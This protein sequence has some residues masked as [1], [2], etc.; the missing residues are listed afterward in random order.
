MIIEKDIKNS[1]QFSIL[2]YNQKTTKKNFFS[3]F[4]YGID[5]WL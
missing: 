5:S 3:A 2:F 4:L 1:Q